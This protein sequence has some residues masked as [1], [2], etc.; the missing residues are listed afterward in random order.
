MVINKHINKIAILAFITILVPT[1]AIAQKITPEAYINKYHAIA[2]N[3]ML[4][5]GIPASITLAQGLLESGNGNSRLATEGNN[6]FGIKC[7]KEWTGPSMHLDDDA[8][9]E[10]FRK[11][12]NPDESYIDH[13]DFL[14]TR[15]RYAFLFDLETTDYKGWAHGLK[16]AGYATN[17]QYAQKLIELIERYNLQRFDD[18]I[19]MNALEMN[20]NKASK[21]SKRKPTDDFIIDLNTKHEVKYNNGVKYIEVKPG[22]SFESICE[23]F[24]MKKWEIYHYND[25]PSGSSIKYHKYLYIQSKRN[26][27]HASHKTHTMRENETLFAVG[28]KY[29]VKV[30][31]LQKY[32]SLKRGEEPKTGQVIQLRPAIKKK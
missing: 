30:K 26:K 13:T 10:C 22:D 25:I 9:N 32:N 6:H 18:K 17:P 28:H 24:G 1:A 11:Y 21:T 8:P 2:V 20:N 14:R 3:E 31:K 19:D 29:G 15:S 23:E 12:G 4:R 16:Q 5:S 7:H 27:A